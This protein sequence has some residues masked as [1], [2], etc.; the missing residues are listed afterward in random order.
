MRFKKLAKHLASVAIAFSILGGS[1]ASAATV[2][3]ISGH[4]A[5]Q[6]IEWMVGK[7]FI[8]GYTDGTF[9]PNNS[10]TRAEFATI[11]VRSGTFDREEYKGIF[12]DVKASDWHAV[13]I[14]TAYEQGWI[15]G[16]DGK[17]RPN[18]KISRAEMAVIMGRIVKSSSKDPV[19][20]RNMI[21][22]VFT[23]RANIPNWSKDDMAYAIE[24]GIMKGGTG[25]NFFPNS[26]STRAEA[27]T[28]TYNTLEF[29]RKIWGLDS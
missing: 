3:D 20:G 27:A 26:H 10:I 4:W 11:L 14:Q 1:M 23:D 21:S 17:F 29:F 12:Q 22:N 9:K 5:K 18:D 13:Y 2:S 16:S 19:N 7:E 28:V 8:T 15:K 24:N 25:N 6:N